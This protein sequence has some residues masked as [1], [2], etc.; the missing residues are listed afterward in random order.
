MA[1]EVFLVLRNNPIIAV[2]YFVFTWVPG[3]LTLYF[4]P[5]VMSHNRAPLSILIN[6]LVTAFVLSGI[7]NMCLT[8][9]EER[10]NPST[11][12]Q[13]LSRY[14]IKVLLMCLFGYVLAL[15]IGIFPIVFIPTVF[16]NAASQLTFSLAIVAIVF[17]PLLT[18]WYPAIF[19]D[20]LQG[21]ESLKRGFRLG[22]KTYLLQ[23]IELIILFAIMNLYA[24]IPLNHSSYLYS[25]S[26]SALVSIL[27]VLY[28]I[29][30]FTIYKSV[31]ANN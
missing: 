11:F 9:F 8:A 15:T 30:L 4:I 20:N 6:L 21:Y 10:I 24:K 29:S 22:R 19:V 14:F 28:I 2:F 18:L 16:I 27:S 17:I 3:L 1:R 26:Q 13:G 23:L 5:E 25:L 31:N 12:V 7:G